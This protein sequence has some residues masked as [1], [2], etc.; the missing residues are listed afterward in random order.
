MNLIK[1]LLNILKTKTFIPSFREDIKWNLST[2][3][4]CQTL[5][6]KLFFQ[7]LNK[8]SSDSSFFIILFKFFS[9]LLWTISPNWTHINH[10][11]SILYESS[12]IRVNQIFYLLIG[13][14]KSAMYLRQ[15]L[16]NFFNLSSP[17]SSLIDLKANFWPFFKLN[18]PFSE[19]VKSA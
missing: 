18:N 2:Y 3:W 6:P 16:M 1:V 12:S 10:T 14:S 19:K 11:S 13:I 7:S 17:S 4:K 5:C 9:F 15:K 8:L